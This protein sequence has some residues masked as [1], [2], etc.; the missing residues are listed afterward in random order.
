M[1]SVWV[2]RVFGANLHEIVERLVEGEGR[3]GGRGGADA[4]R[5]ALPLAGQARPCRHARHG[6]GLSLAGFGGP[7]GEKAGGRE[8][9]GS[10]NGRK[11]PFL[12]IAN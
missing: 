7:L 3:G 8:N 9:F 2:W 1:L 10:N 11:L 4:G 6:C 5:F 12:G